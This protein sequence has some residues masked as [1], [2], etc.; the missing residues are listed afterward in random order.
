MWD[1]LL[2]RGLL[3]PGTTEPCGV[4]PGVMEGWESSQLGSVLGSVLAQQCDSGW[5]VQPPHLLWSTPGVTVSVNDAL[6]KVVRMTP[7]KCSSM[8]GRETL[9]PVIITVDVVREW[10]P[11]SRVLG[12]NLDRV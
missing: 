11:G 10:L 8:N 6:G 9:A 7:R 4:G 5:P 2:V 3:G 1:K 12:C